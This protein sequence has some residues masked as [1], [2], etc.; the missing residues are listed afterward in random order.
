MPENGQKSSALPESWIVPVR[1]LVYV[2]LAGCSAYV[3]FNVGD[4][5]LTHYLIIISIVAVSAMAL[6]DCRMSADYWHKQANRG[7]HSDNS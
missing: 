5:E 7:K 2:V 3:Y 4:L 1:L 6:L